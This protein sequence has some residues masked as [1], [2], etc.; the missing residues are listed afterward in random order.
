[1][2][3]ETDSKLFHVNFKHIPF[4][5]TQYCKILKLHKSLKIN[6]NLGFSDEEGPKTLR[7][8]IF[9]KEKTAIQ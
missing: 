4:Y 7:L 8:S 6:L 2:N 9:P 3:Q 5:A 1:M